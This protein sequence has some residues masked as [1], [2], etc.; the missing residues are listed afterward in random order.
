MSADLKPCLHPRADHQHGTALAYLKDGC[1]CAPCRAAGSRDAKETAHRTHTGT[2]TYVPADRARAHVLALLET[3]TVGQIER[4]SGVDRTSIRVLIG[5]FPGRPQSKRI[6]RA[7]E[8]GLL[9]VRATTVGPE[10]SGLVD[11]TGTRRRLRALV[12]L[13]WTARELTRRLGFSTRTTWVLLHEEAAPVNA[14]TRAAVVA[15]YDELA[16]KTPAPSRGTTRARNVAATHGWVPPLAWD[17]DE[18]DDP[19]A[20]PDTG[21]REKLRGTRTEN[22][23]WL[24]EQGETVETIADRWGVAVGYVEGLLRKADAA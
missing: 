24:V 6:T 4:R 18:I 9:G 7:T 13:G 23:R 16:M 12:A 17:D 11:P 21:G 1:R 22:A 15:L 14:S 8:A 3:L 10:T 19:A 5:D 2:H 20:T